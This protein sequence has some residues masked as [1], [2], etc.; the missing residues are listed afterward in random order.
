MNFKTLDELF[1]AWK[2][3]HC[4]EPDKSC[5][6]TFPRKYEN[7]EIIS[8]PKEFKNSFCLDGYLSD[9]KSFNK[10]LF[11]LKESNTEGNPQTKDFFWFKQ[12]LDKELN[13]ETLSDTYWKRYRDNMIWYL[14]NGVGNDVDYSKCAYMNLNKRGG[15]GKCDNVQ[16]SNYVKEYRSFIEDQIRIINP[17]HIFCCGV[18]GIS[19]CDL[20]SPII[21]AS[22][23][24]A[25]I[26]KC[27][28]LCYRFGN[29][30][31]E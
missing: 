10:I 24:N 5:A 18:D 22:E 14:D 28:H 7:N 17:T 26:F 13:G 19:V 30:I 4:D 31:Y 15:Y 23:T 8:P 2:T 29:K 16:L 1:K 11:I 20:V 21:K 3:A 25:T 6:E 27:R 12:C 9:E